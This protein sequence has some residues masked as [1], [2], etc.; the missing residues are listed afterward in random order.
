MMHTRTVGTAHATCE[1]GTQ[2]RMALF[3]AATELFIE[4]GDSVPLAQICTTADAHP[5]QVTYYLHQ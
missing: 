5:N 1:S 4:H 3:N 2:T